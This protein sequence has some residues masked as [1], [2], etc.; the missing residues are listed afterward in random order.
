[1]HFILVRPICNNDDA[2]GFVYRGSA[3]P[4]LV[5]KY[6]SADFEL[7]KLYVLTFDEANPYSNTVE[8]FS[9]SS[10]CRVAFMTWS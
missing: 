7:D 4:S 9:I 10:V 6:I 5:G 1:V 8:A 2:G 3:C